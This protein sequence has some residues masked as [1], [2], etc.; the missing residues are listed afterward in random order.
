MV[1]LISQ[2]QESPIL[3][4]RHFFFVVIFITHMRDVNNFFLLLQGYKKPSLHRAQLYDD[5]SISGMS[6]MSGMNSSHSRVSSVSDIC[7]VCSYLRE[8]KLK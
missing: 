2:V 1:I 7:P 3:I 6:G 4:P 5:I 8:K